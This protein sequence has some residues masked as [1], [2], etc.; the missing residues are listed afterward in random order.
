MQ[1]SC[2][3]APRPKKRRRIAIPDPLRSKSF[4]NLPKDI[5]RHIFYFLASMKTLEVTT[6]RP[7]NPFGFHHLSPFCPEV[8]VHIGE[9]KPYRFD[10]FLAKDCAPKEV[11]NNAHKNEVNWS[12]SPGGHL[13]KTVDITI[14]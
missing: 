8:T 11:T 2:P 7:P 3:D 1:L 4:A 6:F 12:F 5:K 10:V 9:F 13:L 14:V